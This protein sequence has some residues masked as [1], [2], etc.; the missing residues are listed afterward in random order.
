MRQIGTELQDV[1]IELFLFLGLIP[2]EFAEEEP[3]MGSRIISG[4]RN[5]T[6]SRGV[7]QWFQTGFEQI[8]N[9]SSHRCDSLCDR[10][11]Y[12]KHDQWEWKKVPIG[13]CWVNVGMCG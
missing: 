2:G 6:T 11:T 8:F 10:M 7:G 3:L 13:W 5:K 9:E 1:L 4:K 12:P